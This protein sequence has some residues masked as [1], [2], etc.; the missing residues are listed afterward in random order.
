MVRAQGDQVGVCGARSLGTIY[1]VYALL[2]RL[3]VEFYAPSCEVVPRTEEL[4][5]PDC[6][7]S[8][9]PRYE[10]RNVTGNLKLG[11]TPND[12][13]GNPSEIG[14]SGNIVHSADYL[15][16]FSQYADT[17]PE[18][19]ALQMD[20]KRLHREDGK[21]PQNVHLCLSNPDVRRISAER[22]LEL[23]DKQPDRMF[24][25]VS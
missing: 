18:Y 6:G 17:Q 23:I 16:P 7:F 4:I 19:F 15:V 1:G 24:F 14:Q 11:Q 8:A 25:G 10:F 13:M 9:R 22:M 3:G 12:D 5:I 2:E 21:E 20:G